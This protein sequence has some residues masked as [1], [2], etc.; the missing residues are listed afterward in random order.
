VRFVLRLTPTA[1]WFSMKLVD[2]TDRQPT[3]RVCAR[4]AARGH[5]TPLSYFVLKNVP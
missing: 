5:S 4:S 3:S 1:Q 2:A